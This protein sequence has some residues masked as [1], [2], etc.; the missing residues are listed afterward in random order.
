MCASGEAGHLRRAARLSLADVA[1][2]VGVEP[3]TVLR[4]ER[5]AAPRGERA[6]RYG[7]L[8]WRLAVLENE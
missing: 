6:Q 3:S 8:L 5:G 4:W 1:N 7:D 2:V